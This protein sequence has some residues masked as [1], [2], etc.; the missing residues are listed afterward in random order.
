MAVAKH[1]IFDAALKANGIGEEGYEKPNNAQIENTKN[2]AASEN[3][4]YFDML[5]NGDNAR[6]EKL[7]I[8]TRNRGRKKSKV[9]CADI[10]GYSL[11]MTTKS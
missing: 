1:R 9:S 5:V 2:I 11:H 4:V 6:S 8:S 7:E 10:G 3:M